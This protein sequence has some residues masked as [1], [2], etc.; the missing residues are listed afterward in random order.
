MAHEAPTDDELRER[1][2]ELEAELDRERSDRARLRTLVDTIPDLIFVIGREGEVEFVNASAAAWLGRAADQLQDQH[3]RDLFPPATAAEF[4]E[5]LRA[6]MATGESSYHE[7]MAALPDG[8]RWLSTWL[9]PRLDDEGNVVGVMGVSRD[10]TESRQDAERLETL[11][12]HLPVSLWVVDASQRVTFSA[13]AGLEAIGLTPEEVVGKPVFELFPSLTGWRE[14]IP[15][16]RGGGTVTTSSKIR[17]AVLESRL[18]MLTAPDGTPRG[19]MGVSIDISERVAVAEALERELVRIERLESLGVL[20]GG[21]AHDF[22][23]LLAAL[24]G[25]IG[26][27]QRRAADRPDLA[28][29]LAAAE[30]AAL[31]A[32]DLTQELLTFSKGG[33][34]VRRALA[35][36][37]LLES[38]AGLVLHG[39]PCK[40]VIRVPGDLWAVHADPTQLGQV[41]QNLVLNAV[42]AMPDGGEVEVAASN[43]TLDETSGLPL[44]A[45]RYVELAVRDT[46]LGID[47]ELVDRVF[48]PYFTT[49]EAGTGLGL[50]TVHSVVRR[51]GGHTT[52]RSTPGSGTEVRVL[53]PATDDKPLQVTTERNA[54]EGTLQGR[55]L[56]VDDEPAVRHMIKMLLG[57]LG[58]D[59]EVAADGAEGLARYDQAR[60][61]DAPFDAIVV[62]LTIP[63]GMGG[64]TM[65]RQLLDRDPN[66]RAIV[67]SGYSNDPIMSD[68]AAHGFRGV[69]AKP[70]RAREL[71]EVLRR[72]LDEP[73]Q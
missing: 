45:G 46:G 71:A 22:N 1:I 51:H 20:A 44:P 37:P 21:F 2:R 58:F 14:F 11:L 40:P 18:R 41:V 31:R 49:K 59:T 48:D 6:A 17:G 35:V 70:Y 54:A 5:S 39:S 33:A 72:V 3:V 25:S 47:P 64:K 53:L 50:A 27:A 55:V 13:G 7:S 67:S 30:E 23:N 15:K 24:L 57:E 66:A 36:G 32:R 56:V 10:M 8:E 26:V 62:D 60:A 73:L 28:K 4:L 38:A 52:L 43:E 29:P 42:Q 19:I 65:I 69:V 9:Q 61:S 68:F 16:L 63:G 12:Q 34:P